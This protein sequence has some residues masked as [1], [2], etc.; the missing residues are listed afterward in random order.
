MIAQFAFLLPGSEE[1]LNLGR[2]E[3]LFFFRSEQ[4]LKSRNQTAGQPRMDAN[5]I[6]ARSITPHGGGER[7]GVL[8]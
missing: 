2:S 3:P 7:G 6:G 4:A 8:A 1:R 5:G